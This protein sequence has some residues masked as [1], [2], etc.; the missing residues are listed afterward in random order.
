[1]VSLHL[2]YF[3]FC[4][5]LLLWLAIFN[6]VL[7]ELLNLRA[8][9][10]YPFIDVADLSGINLDNAGSHTAL[11]GQNLNFISSSSVLRDYLNCLFWVH[12]I[13]EE[14]IFVGY[15]GSVAGFRWQAE[16]TFCVNTKQVKLSCTSIAGTA[17]IFVGVTKLLII[18]S[19][20][21][22]IHGKLLRTYRC[23]IIPMLSCISPILHI[24]FLYFHYNSNKILFFNKHLNR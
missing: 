16:A 21:I 6:E 3:L 4:F 5:Y 24:S 23:G 20:L 14:V 19:I 9:Q 11:L 7:H 17:F 13:H 8:E 1:M 18:P 12:R 15:G 22:L 10:S 2:F